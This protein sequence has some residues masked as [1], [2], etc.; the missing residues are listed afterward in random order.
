MN[1]RQILNQMLSN[2]GVNNNPMAQNILNMANS[3]NIQGIEQIGRNIAKERNIDFDK[4][5]TEFKR[6]LGVK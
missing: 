1:P 3:G 5:F 6:Q 2:H 4:A